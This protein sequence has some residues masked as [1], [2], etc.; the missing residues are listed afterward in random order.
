MVNLF[1]TLMQAQNGQAVD[2]MARQFK[3][4]QDQVETALAALMPAF[5][6]GFKRNASDPMG[7]GNW[8][9]AVATGRHAKYFEDLTHAFAPQGIEEG[10][11]ILGHVFG[12][13]EVSRA[14]AAQAAQATGLGQELLKQML[15][16][17]ASALMGGMFKQMNGQMQ[18]PQAPQGN[19]FG[20]VI[21]QMMKAATG[22]AATPVNRNPNPLDN[23]F[24]QA[25]EQIF[26][27]G[28]RAARDIAHNRG[29]M[30]DPLD[31]D[32]NPWGKMLKEMM[33][34]GQQRPAPAPVPAPRSKL[35]VEDMFGDMFDA[36]R[37]S[38]E[39]FQQ[40]Y[41]RSMEEVFDTYRKGMD[42]LYRG[43]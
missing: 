19:V 18:A 15:P 6:H 36:G 35:P 2:A 33:G 22:Q 9:Q 13:K 41:Q 30:P 26:G 17:I 11:G 3:L 20:Q 32:N 8:M 43:G 28:G 23:P 38:Q 21:E 1:E 31:P 16:V 42:Q 24:G 34:A 37:K 7:L 12:S 4:N 10:N 39:Q 27:N 40:Q 14:V 25:L 5:A 29:R